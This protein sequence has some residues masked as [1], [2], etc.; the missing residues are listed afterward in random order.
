MLRYRIRLTKDDNGTFLV[1]VPD[2][3]EVQTY[4]ETKDEAK[5]HA[6][7]AILTAFDAYMKGKRPIPQPSSVQ[8]ARAYV[9]IPPLDVA[10]IELYRAMRDSGTGK[11]RLA[12][13]LGW[14]MPQ[15][16]RV[17]ALRYRSRFDQVEQ[18]LAAVGKRIVVSVENRS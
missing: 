6:V 15:L 2:V 1:S 17:L 18:A 3:P 7:D 8:H 12:K 14:Y 13:K 10:K 4:G 5:A 11:Y 9:E 16:D